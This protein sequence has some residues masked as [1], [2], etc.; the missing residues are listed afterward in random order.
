MGVLYYVLA[1][2]AATAIAIQA[3]INSRLGQALIGQP[4]LAALVSFTVGTVAL[5]IL[6]LFRADFNQFGSTILQQ[7]LWKLSGGLLGAFMVFCSAY[8]PLKIGLG[9]F[10]F[11]IVAVQLTVGLII[12]QFG[13]FGMP[14]RPVDSWRLLGATVMMGGLGIFFFGEKLAKQL[15]W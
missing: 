9:N 12:D 11:I 14:S 8:L 4:L 10:L 3:P 13:L 7:P 1:G 5:L 15:G 2:M 6:C